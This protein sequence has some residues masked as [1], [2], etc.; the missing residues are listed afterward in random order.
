MSKAERT[1]LHQKRASSGQDIST[2]VLLRLAFGGLVASTFQAF[3]RATAFFNLTRS[4]GVLALHPGLNLQDTK[5]QERVSKSTTTNTKQCRAI[6]PQL[7]PY[8][9]RVS[10]PSLRVWVAP[11]GLRLTVIASPVV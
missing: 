1:G 8:W 7:L 10:P 6:I 11:Y 4:F 9:R 5:K 2:L 3:S